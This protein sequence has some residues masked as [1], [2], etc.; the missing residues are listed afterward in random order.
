MQA[1]IV[2]RKIASAA[3]YLAELLDAAGMDGDPSTDRRAVAL[4]ALK[5]KFGAMITVGVHIFKQRRSFPDVQHHDVHIAGVKDVAESGT[6]PAFQ[7]QGLKTGFL[8]DLVE[9]SVAIVAMEQKRFTVTRAGFHAIHLGKNVSIGDEDI[10]PGVVVHVKEAGAPAHQAIVLLSD[11]GSPAHVLETLRAEIFV[12]TVGLLGKMRDEEAEQSAVVEV[13]EINVHVAELKAFADERQAG[14]HADVRKGAVVIVVVEVVGNG[15]IGDEQV[16]P[17]IIIVVRPHHTQ[18]VIAD[19][20]AN[21]SFCRDFFKSAVA[22]IVIEEVAFADEP[23]RAALHQDTFVAAVFVATETRQVVHFHV[24]VAGDEEVHVAVAVVI[25]P[26]RSGHEAAAADTGFFRDV[27]K[28]A[29]AKVSI[30]GAAAVAA[31][32]QIEVAVVI[33]VRD[34]DAHAPAE[35]REARFLSDVLEGAIRFLMVKSDHGIAAGAVAFDRRSID[36]NNVLAA[37]PIAIEQTNTATHRL[38]NEALLARGDVLH[39]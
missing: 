20:V 16:R 9:R 37:V 5:V 21:A 33:E 13:G 38:Q 24:R 35:P 25:S 12:K 36:D 31:N 15:I 1:Q 32:K 4:C 27:L 7:R 11:A 10:G 26:R 28:F 23:P 29:V 19:F 8:R 18:A 22:T 34:G 14:E 30:E 2:L 39:S 17:T 6:A 3:V